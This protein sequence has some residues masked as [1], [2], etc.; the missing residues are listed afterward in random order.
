MEAWSGDRFGGF[1]PGGDVLTSQGGREGG[2]EAKRIKGG[3]ELVENCNGKM[4]ALM[5]NPNETSWWPVKV[6]LLLSLY[7]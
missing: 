1:H 7:Y 5:R 3:D 4:R 2:R 6:F